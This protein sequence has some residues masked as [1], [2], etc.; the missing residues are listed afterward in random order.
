MNSC[1]VCGRECKE[2]KHPGFYYCWCCDVAVKG[3]ENIATDKE[4]IQTYGD[5]W[6]VAQGKN[7]TAMVKA[8]YLVKMIDKVITGEKIL[9]IGCGSGILVGKLSKAGYI[10]HGV[11]W[12]Q[13]AIEYA[14]RNTVGE[15]TVA[16]INYGMTDIKGKYDMV[17]ASHILEHIENPDMFFKEIR[18]VLKPYGYIVVAV[19]NL[20]WY[21]LK[22]EWRQVSTIFDPEH[23]VCYKF[24]GLAK[25]LMKE[26]F[27]VAKITTRTHGVS[28]LTAMGV[29]L[30]SKVKGKKAGTGD[31]KPGSYGKIQK[32]YDAVIGNSLFNLAMYIPNRIS[33]EHFRGMELIMVARWMGYHL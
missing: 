29:T 15:Y 6:V 13:P 24:R 12:S 26:G 20:D 11:D 22:P 27:S 2:E 1:L 8:D 14:K 3:L 31:G 32:L 28:L 33:E 10:A 9:D 23:S 4:R 7:K 16:D 18:R 21:G 5:D 19:P 25:L 30:Y 17:V